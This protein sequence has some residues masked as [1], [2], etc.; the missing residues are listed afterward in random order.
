MKKVS[1]DCDAFLRELD[2]A[3]IDAEKKELRDIKKKLIERVQDLAEKADTSTLKCVN[4]EKELVALSA[5]DKAEESAP[6]RTGRDRKP[7]TFFDD[8]DFD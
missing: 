4:Y 8:I 5:K 1:N 6:R 3:K 7:K 2:G